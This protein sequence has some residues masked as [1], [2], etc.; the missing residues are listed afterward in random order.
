MPTSL[1]ASGESSLPTI[2]VF[3]VG[4]PGLN[5][6]EP[7]YTSI[8]TSFPARVA[9]PMSSVLLTGC[10]MRILDDDFDMK[11]ARPGYVRFEWDGLRQ[12]VTYD[13]KMG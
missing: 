7:L 6:E 3:P 9:A 1:S 5:T 12:V 10:P 4:V 13:R 2:S 8:S 11:R